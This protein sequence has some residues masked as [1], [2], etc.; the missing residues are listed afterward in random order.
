MAS[1]LTSDVPRRADARRNRERLLTAAAAAFAA[2]GDPSLEKVARDA[3]V[4]I[5]TLYRHFPSREALVEAVYRGE[6]A[7]VCAAADD[8]LAEHEPAAAL[9]L[10]LDR[11]ADFVATKRGMADTFRAM[12]GDGTL[13]SARTR[14]SVDGAVATLL[15]AG[16]RAGSLRGDVEPDD[17]VTLLVGTFVAVDGLDDRARVARLLDLVCDGL[18]PRA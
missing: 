15:A 18:R 5:G 12:V 14:E 8:L 4:G 1:A 6:L 10:W 13:A 11:Y 7:A 2:G 16:A 17:V 3:G 9:R